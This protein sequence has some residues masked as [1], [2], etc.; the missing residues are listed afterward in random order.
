MT[1]LQSFETLLLCCSYA[2]L[3]CSG[4]VAWDGFN[5]D[6]AWFDVDVSPLFWFQVNLDSTI[7]LAKYAGPGAWNDPDILEVRKFCTS[8]IVIILKIILLSIIV[9]I[10][11]PRS[12]MLWCCLVKL[13]LLNTQSFISIIWCLA[14]TGSI[15]MIPDML[16]FLYVM[17]A[18][19]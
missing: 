6:R 17:C 15:I 12:R 7:G 13:S 2:K 3:L 18:V 10:I 1:S 5:Q 14:M 16:N 8:L 11:C 9:M 19:L 4:I